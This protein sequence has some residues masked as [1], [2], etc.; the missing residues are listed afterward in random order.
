MGLLF[1]KLGMSISCLL[2]H[3]K[4]PQNF[5][6]QNNNHFLLFI[7]LQLGQDSAGVAGPLH[8]APAGVSPLGG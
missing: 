3:N 5:I 4:L 2:L 6:A 7:D 1:F 8:A